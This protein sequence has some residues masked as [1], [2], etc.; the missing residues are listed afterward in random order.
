MRRPEQ[1][2]QHEVKRGS[3]GTWCSD[4]TA[5]RRRGIAGIREG[6]WE[7]CAM[8]RYSVETETR[9]KIGDLD[10]TFPE[11][12]RWCFITGWAYAV[13]TLMIVLTLAL[14]IIAILAIIKA[15]R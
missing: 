7:N 15:M 14:P 4:T 10:V 13:A 6:S 3:K 11:A 9:R 12:L 8:E 5:T 1:G 2:A